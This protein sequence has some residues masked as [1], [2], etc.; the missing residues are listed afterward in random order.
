MEQVMG[1]CLDRGIKVVSNAGGLSPAL[2]GGRGRGRGQARPAPASP[3]SRATTSCPG[4]RSCGRGRGLLHLD[5]GE[6][7]GDRPVI[8]A[9]AYLGGWGIAEALGGAPT[10]W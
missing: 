7:L 2:R 10:S 4:W 9:N 5:T 1:A 6:P 3:T 8:T